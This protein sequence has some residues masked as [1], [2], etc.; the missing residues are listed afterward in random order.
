M[1]YIEPYDDWDLQNNIE[2]EHAFSLDP[3][4]SLLLSTL[5]SNRVL[6]WLVQ[7]IEL[8][9][10]GEDEPD[11]DQLIVSMQPNAALATFARL[12][13]KVK[14]LGIND[15]IWYS[16][17]CDRVVQR[18]L[19]D[20]QTIR[21]MTMT[22]QT[23]EDFLRFDGVTTIS[24]CE[25]TL[26]PSI[27]ISP[28]LAASLVNITLI[29]CNRTSFKQIQT[30]TWSTLRIL[31]IPV[32]LVP[33]LKLSRFPHLEQLSFGRPSD[34]FPMSSQNFCRELAASKSI[35][36]FELQAGAQQ[37]LRSVWSLLGV[38]LPPS[39]YRV[40]LDFCRSFD[41]ILSMSQQAQKGHRIRQLALSA[42][43]S[44]ES[45]QVQQHFLRAVRTLLDTIGV[46][47]IWC[48]Y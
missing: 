21:F 27:A 9:E 8:E 30:P 42:A 7:R 37:S 5:L 40:D 14:H 18:Y 46:E 12:C 20:L 1:N 10:T 44:S 45:S 31:H 15:N 16:E 35:K 28:R 22:S 38:S 34:E 25:T 11:R 32:S 47:L 41:L 13:P 4:S 23:W 33:I 36:V 6:G 19:D 2:L 26:S 29:R 24:S 39:C 3:S 17:P 48:G 43:A